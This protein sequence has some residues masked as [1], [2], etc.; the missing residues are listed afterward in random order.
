VK[1]EYKLPQAL[2]GIS[3][4]ASLRIQETAIF[5]EVFKDAKSSVIVGSECSSDWI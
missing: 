4:F 1:F 5:G 2:V 3:A